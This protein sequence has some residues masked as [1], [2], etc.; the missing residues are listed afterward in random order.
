MKINS[1]P[2]LRF[3]AFIEWAKEQIDNFAEM[4]RKQ[5]YSPDVAAK[6]VEEAIQ[7]TQSQSKKVRFSSKILTCLNIQ[8][9][10]LFS[11]WKSLV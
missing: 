7:V 5:V 11:F 1:T 9:H 4:F 3:S 8:S 6:T 10:H 2:I